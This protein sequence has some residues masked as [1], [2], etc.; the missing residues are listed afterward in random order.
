[1]H[2]VDSIFERD[3]GLEGPAWAR[4]ALCRTEDPAI[5]FGPNRFEPKHE[6]IA[7]EE[8]AKKVCRQCPCMAACRSHA[9]A[10]GE[11]Y[12]VWGGLGEADRREMLAHD[13][14]VATAV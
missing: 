4:E 7:R 13:P 12:G 6:R 14:S 9:I 1:M 5:F 2:R 3:V 8:A 10:T 11:S